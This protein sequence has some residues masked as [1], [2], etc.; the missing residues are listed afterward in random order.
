V[1]EAL[2]SQGMF[3][4]LVISDPAL[5]SDELI[6]TLRRETMR[7]WKAVLEE[8]V[9]VFP[10]LRET[11][12]VLRGGGVRLAIYTGS[13]GESFA[14]LEK[15]GLLDFFE[16]ILTRADVEQ[17]KPHPEGILRC[18]EALN[19]AP[20]QAA[21]VGDSVPD[22]SAGLAA[23]VQ[24]IGMLTGAAD[25]AALSIAGAHR[26]AADYRSLLEILLPDWQT[27]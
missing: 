1:R 4:D 25:S 16:V 2:N 20:A 18:L 7:H 3:W 23:G 6:A 27:A 12:E 21:Y 17:A 10:G 15:A 14:P 11:L 5:R 8:Q 22:M 13:R 24:A 19:V 9:V 26:L